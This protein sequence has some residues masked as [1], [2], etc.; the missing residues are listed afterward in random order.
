MRLHHSRYF[1]LTVIHPDSLCLKLWPLDALSPSRSHDASNHFSWNPHAYSVGQNTRRVPFSTHRLNHAG[2]MRSIIVT[3]SY[4]MACLRRYSCRQSQGSGSIQSEVA[5]VSDRG[6]GWDLNPIA[7]GTYPQLRP[8]LWITT[9][10]IVSLCL[11]FSQ[12]GDVSEFDVQ[13]AFITRL[14]ECTPTST[15]LPRP[16]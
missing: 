12:P 13:F 2:C 1:S 4:S 15:P 11:T 5:N 9:S 16:S 10:I 6:P 14:N 7:D 3:R 8:F